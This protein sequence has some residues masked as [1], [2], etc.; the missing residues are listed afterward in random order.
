[1]KQENKIKKKIKLARIEAN[2]TQ[3]EL[4]KK[5]KSSQQSVVAW[6]KGSFVPS[7]ENI[8]KIAKATGKTLNYF[9]D[10]SGNIATDN[11]TITIGE[12]RKPYYSK[13]LEF[14]LLKK[15]IEL[16]KKEVEIIKLKLKLKK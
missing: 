10:N 6:E 12:E 1:M 8:K 3:T 11:S 14:D 7:L 2:L 13:Q 5:V 16:L 15:E 9:F 4:A